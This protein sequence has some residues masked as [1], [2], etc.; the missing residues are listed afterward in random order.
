LEEVLNIVRGREAPPARSRSRGVPISDHVLGTL[1]SDLYAA[2]DVDG[3]EVRG[4][5]R[6]GD[7]ID[8]YLSGPPSD[9]LYDVQTQAH[10]EAVEILFVIDP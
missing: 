6:H 7:R 1:M 3:V 8:M 2:A 4:I 5:R 9:L 10:K